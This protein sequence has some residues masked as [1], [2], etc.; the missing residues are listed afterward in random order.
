M[1]RQFSETN[2]SASNF[3]RSAGMLDKLY[4]WHEDSKQDKSQQTGKQLLVVENYEERS[5]I[6]H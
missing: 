2:F 6:T 3:P 1:R 4:T 5:K